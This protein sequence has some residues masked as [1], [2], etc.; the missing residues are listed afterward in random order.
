MSTIINIDELVKLHELTLRWIKD[1]REVI[2]E[3]QNPEVE[4][5]TGEKDLV[6]EIDRR[7]EN[8]FKEFIAQ[9]YPHH[10]IRGEESFEVGKKYSSEHL[11]IIDPIDGTSNFVKM[12]RDYCVLLAYFENGVPK[13]SYVLDVYE[14]KLYY[15]MEGKGVYL[16][17]GKL[18]KPESLNLTK[19]LICIDVLRMEN[20][21]EKQ[22][23]LENTF[24]LRYVGC[25]GLD[26]I[27][28]IEGKFGAFLNPSGGP[29]DAAPFILMAK[30]QGLKMFT[31][32][33]KSMDLI[34]RSDFYIGSEEIYQEILG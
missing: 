13:L 21:K 10:R 32:E 27:T 18:E 7:I 29:L 4:Y 6:T 22:L 12:K 17:G 30:E 1:Y 8:S 19:S 14:N 23:I 28:V 9:N 11:W 15:S 16:N 26:G 5:K 33:G 2:L 34:D 25:S 3:N 20:W 24:D 31:F